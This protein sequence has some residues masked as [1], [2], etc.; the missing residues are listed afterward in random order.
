MNYKFTLVELLTVIGIIAVLASILLPSLNK[1]KDQAQSI[2]CMGQVRQSGL[3]I[4]NYAND[5][6]NF[7]PALYSG[8]VYWGKVLVDYGYV[9]EKLNNSILQCPNALP[10]TL[11]SSRNKTYGMMRDAPYRGIDEV[12]T[13][14]LP[15]RMD[16]SRFPSEDILIADS[17]RVY[18]DPSNI[19]VFTVYKNYNATGTFQIQT[20]HLNNANLFFYD[21]HA[22]SF[23]L[24]RIKKLKTYN[25]PNPTAV[26]SS[27]YAIIDK[28][29]L[30]LKWAAPN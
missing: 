1:A 25:I 2:R 29:G 3:A 18:P 15:Y 19:Q 4:S 28:N 16:S 7:R 30:I 23:N 9:S 27:D 11:D 17:L 8:S 14:S 26:G 21:G 10:L 6:Q 20:R 24:S 12:L 22:G 5:H 13:S